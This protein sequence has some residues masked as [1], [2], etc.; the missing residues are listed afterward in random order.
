MNTLGQVVKSIEVNSDSAVCN[1]EDLKAGV[2]IVRIYG[3]SLRRAEPVEASLSKGAA[4]FQRKFIK[5]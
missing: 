2:Y 4:I 3:S 1:V 5:E